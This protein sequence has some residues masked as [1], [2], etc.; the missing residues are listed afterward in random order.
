MELIDVYR[1]FYPAT[2]QYTS[3]SAAHESFSKLD[4]ILGHKASL[5]KFKKI[6]ITPCIL[7][8]HNAIKLELNNK[9]S[10]RK[11]ARNWRLDNTFL[12][13]QWVREEIGRK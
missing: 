7:S 1:V 4:H 10:S 6:E 8:D 3:F 12:N 9:S 11:Y 5:N 13:N 2:A